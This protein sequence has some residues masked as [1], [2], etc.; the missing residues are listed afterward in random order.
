MS[1][2]TR[3]SIRDHFNLAQ[4]AL[5]IAISVGTVLITIGATYGTFY[6][7]LNNVETTTEQRNK[8]RSAQL[9]ELKEEIRRDIVPRSENQAHW[10]ATNKRLDDIQESLRDIHSLLLRPQ[11]NQK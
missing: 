6:T 9:D 3:P 1:T 11:I 5:G 4:T 2:S 8:E 7:R 10:E